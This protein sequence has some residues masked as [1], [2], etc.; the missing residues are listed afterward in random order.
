MKIDNNTAA[1]RRWAHPTNIMHRVPIKV[2]RKA[3]EA[4]FCSGLLIF[5]ACSLARSQDRPADGGKFDAF[6][7]LNTDDV[8]AHLDRF[9]LEL[10]SNLKLQGFVVIHKRAG[11]AVGWHLRQAYGYLNYLVNSRGVPASRVKV[12]E[13]D[14]GKETGYELWLMP[15]GGAPPVSAPAPKPEPISPVRFDEVSLGNEAKCVGEF[16]IE[17]YKIEDALKLF[18]D[19]LRQ[20]PAS[21]AWIVV[22]PRVRERLATARR[23]INASRSLLTRK[24]G[25]GSE[26][27][28]TA[29]GP[30]HSTICTGVNLWIVPGS[31]SRPDEAGYYSQ[32]M[33]EAQQTEYTVR[34]VEFIGNEHIRDNILRKRF[35]QTEGDV[36][37]K[38]ALEQSLRNLTKLRMIYPVTL[39][40]WRSGWIVKINSW[41][42]RS[43][44]ESGQA[45]LRLTSSTRIKTKGET[46]CV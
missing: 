18:A 38:N 17:L 20:Q 43:T 25:I 40:M 19:A 22:H 10:N 24:Y 30:P 2:V 27:V 33:E 32:L 21:K 45:A 1:M 26:R 3:I 29:M 7:D 42:S 6:G 16:T 46:P 8:M 15:A 31:N 11:S 34:R 5:T 13:A 28:L 9:A 36:F 37:S 14:A 44:L 23:T 41:T 39:K 4:A 35:M 12:L